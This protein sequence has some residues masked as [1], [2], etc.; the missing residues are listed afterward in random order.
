MWL[1]VNIGHGEFVGVCT[2]SHIPVFLFRIKKEICTAQFEDNVGG[3]EWKT[4]VTDVNSHLANF[5]LL[6]LAFHCPVFIINSAL[7][8]P[9]LFFSF[10]CW[11]G[12]GAPKS[13]L[14]RNK[15]K[16]L[17]GEKWGFFCLLF[18]PLKCCHQTQPDCWFS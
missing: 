3:L 12:V 7:T 18:N 11:G 8:G 9:M 1:S 16:Q 13:I 14:N 15:N 10:F 5:L 6:E 17:A 2:L 4:C